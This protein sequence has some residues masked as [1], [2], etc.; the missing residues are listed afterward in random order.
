MKPHDVKPTPAQLAALRL[1]AR[2]VIRYF[3]DVT[4]ARY[5]VAF[6]DTDHTT[7]GTLRACV[8]RRWLHV[9]STAP[10]NA[11]TDLRWKIIAAGRA[12]LKDG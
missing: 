2:G 7:R 3:K 8:A 10:E 9:Y 12:V 5:A 4:G 6:M 11:V 1:A